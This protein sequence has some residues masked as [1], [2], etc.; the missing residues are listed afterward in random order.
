MI[1]KTAFVKQKPFYSIAWNLN[2]IKAKKGQY[3][4]TPERTRNSELKHK[5]QKVPYEIFLK[6]R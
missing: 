2:P 4:E 1:S 3:S 5:Y 6:K